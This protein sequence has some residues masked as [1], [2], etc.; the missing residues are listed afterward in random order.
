MKAATVVPRGGLDDQIEALFSTTTAQLPQWSCP[1]CSQSTRQRTARGCRIW[2]RDHDCSNEATLPRVRDFCVCA[3]P[4]FD[5][6]ECVL[7]GRPSHAEWRKS[8]R[9]LIEIAI[10]SR[11]LTTVT[12]SPDTGETALTSAPAS[13]SSPPCAGAASTVTRSEAACSSLSASLW[14]SCS[15]SCL[16]SSATSSSEQ[17]VPQGEP[18]ASVP[19]MRKADIPRLSLLSL[20]PA[21]THL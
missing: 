11:G 12:E 16:S 1:F 18:A 21:R 7:C 14:C 17:D 5:E 9:R 19:S 6:G 15:G 3:V 13:G 20:R 4:L 10:A 2:Q 8:A